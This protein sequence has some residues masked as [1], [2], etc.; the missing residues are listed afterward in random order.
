MDSISILAEIKQKSADLPRYVEIAD[1]MIDLWGLEGT[2][3]IDVQIE[4]GNS[5]R[6]SLK[7]W[8]KGRPIWF[9]ELP[10]TLCKREKL[11]TGDMVE[12]TISLADNSV[13]DEIQAILENNLE[14]QIKWDTMTAS[15][16][17]MINENVLEGKRP[18]TRERRARK[19]LGGGSVG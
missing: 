9:F 4:G 10:A 6:R 3:P 16:R 15:L 14:A 13:A 5:D 17:R 1:E 18:E 7:R 19:F 11:E 2:T 8:G 12:F